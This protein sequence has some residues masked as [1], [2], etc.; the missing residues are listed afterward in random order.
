MQTHVLLMS[1][2]K[3]DYDGRGRGELKEEKKESGRKLTLFMDIVDDD[4]D[5]LSSHIV[6]SLPVQY[7]R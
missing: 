7:G 6:Q 3:D 4:D 2:N 5:L 1:E